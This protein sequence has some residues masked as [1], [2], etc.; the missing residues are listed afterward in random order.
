MIESQKLNYVRQHQQELRVDKYMNLNACNN[1]PETHGNEK[2]KRIIPPSSF[3]GCRRYMEQLY[4]DGME[5]CGHIGFPDLF[6]TL[7][8]NPAWQKIQ[9]KVRKCNLRHDDCPDVVSR[10]SKMKLSHLMNDLKS[11][12]AFGPIVGCK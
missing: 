12:H 2:G 3:V 10:I 1:D 7:T 11:G 6:L 9:R 5:I 8:C 4:F